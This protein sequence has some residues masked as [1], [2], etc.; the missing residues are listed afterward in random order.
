MC[1]FGAPW[2]EFFIRSQKNDIIKIGIGVGGTFDFWTGKVKRAPIFLRKIG[3]EWMWRL[4]QQPKRM[5]RIF[6]AVI[7]FPIRVIFNK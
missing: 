2:Q 4:I 5:R 7:I 1:N 6:R 3:L